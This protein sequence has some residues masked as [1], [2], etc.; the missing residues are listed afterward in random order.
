MSTDAD[1]LW[2]LKQTKVWIYGFAPKA[3]EGRSELEKE[4]LECRGHEPK[5]VAGQ[6]LEARKVKGT[7]SPLEPPEEGALRTSDSRTARETTCII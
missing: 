2:E 6:P 5:N 7:D 1:V 4:R 3:S